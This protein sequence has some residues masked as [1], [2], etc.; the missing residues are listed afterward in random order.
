[1]TF[2]FGRLTE[3]ARCD[4]L[5]VGYRVGNRF[6]QIDIVE[7]CNIKIHVDEQVLITRD[8]R[9]CHPINFRDGVEFTGCQTSDQIG[10]TG[11]QNH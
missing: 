3:I 5:I 10:L 8:T 4:D 9:D 2:P 1:M 6:A 11:T 7:G